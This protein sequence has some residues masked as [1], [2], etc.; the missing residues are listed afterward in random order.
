MEPY[1]SPPLYQLSYSKKVN[2]LFEPEIRNV[3]KI[4]D[5]LMKHKSVTLSTKSY[6]TWPLT[7]TYI[8]DC[9]KGSKDVI[10]LMLKLPEKLTNTILEET[11]NC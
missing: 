11:V 8:I 9:A 3:P 10:L 6:F 7:I 4:S 2:D 5:P 1:Y